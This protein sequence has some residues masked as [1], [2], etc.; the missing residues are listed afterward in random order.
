MKF[1]KVLL[2]LFFF[3]FACLTDSFG[4]IRS[5]TP[6]SISFVKEMTEFLVT[7]RK[8]E[9]EDYMKKEF[10]PAFYSG[11]FTESDKQKIYK[12]CNIMLKK[13]MKPF[14]DFVNYL[15]TMVNFLDSKQSEESFEAW[16]QSLEKIIEKSTSRKFV[17]FLSFSE[18][19]FSGNIL[20]ESSHLRWVSD[21]N[22]YTFEFDS[23]PFVRFNSLN[24]RCESKNDSTVIYGTKGI[25]YPTEGKW[26]GEGGKVNWLR[27][28]FD[29]ASVYANL[30]KYSVQLS[31]ASYIADSVLFYNSYY[32]DKPILGR[33]EEKILANVTEKNASFP[34]FDS[35]NKR[36][37]IR[38]IAQE[39]DYDGGFSMVG[40]KFIGMGSAEEDAYLIFYKDKTPFLVAASKVFVIQKER[41]ISDNSAITIY[42]GS[43][44]IHHPGL[45]MKFLKLNREL[46]L[47]R[48][49]KGVSKTPYYNTFHKIDMDVEVINWKMGEPLINMEVL[50]GSTQT[51][52]RFESSNYYSQ[53]L[54]RKIMGMDN[55]HPLILIREVSKKLNSRDLLADDIA[56]HMRFPMEQ[57]STLLMNLSTQGFLQYDYEKQKVMLKDKL[58]WYLE[59]NAKTRDYDVIEFNSDIGGKPNASLSLLNF[60]L[61]LRGVHQ[62]HLSDSQNVYINPSNQEVVMKKNRDF[63][64]GGMVNAGLFSFYGKEFFFEYDEFK[65]NL[66]TVDSLAIR[67]KSEEVDDYGR[68]K[69]I[70]VKT[71]IQDIK[72]DL[73]IDGPNNKS[74][75][76]PLAHYP[77][78]NSRQESFVYYNRSSIQ[79]G[80]YSK[81]RFYFKV[82]PFQ[83]DSLN[84]FDN[85]SL[86]FNGLFVSAGIFPD[87]TETLTLQPDYSL[88]FVRKTPAGGYPVYGSKATFENDIKMSHEGLRGDG[89]LK[90]LTST[91]NS[92]DFIFYPDSTNAVMES[93]VIE[94]RKGGAV[95]YPEVTARGAYMHYMPYKD[96]MEVE[97]RKDAIAMFKGQAES[98]G[99]IFL[100]PSGLTGRGLMAFSGAEMDANL[101]KYKNNEF[102]SDTCNFRLASLNSAEFALTTDNLN[103]HVDF[104]TRK[105]KFM[106]NGDGSIMNFPP[107]QYVCYM[108]EFTWL[109]DQNDVEI[110]GGDKV[111]QKEGRTDLDL[112]G[113]TFISTHPKQD[114]LSYVAPKSRY[115]L[116]QQTIYSSGVKYFQVADAMV[117]PGDGEVVVEKRAYMR[118]LKDAKLVANFITKFHNIYNSTV[119]VDGRKKYNA[120]GD[121]DYVDEFDKVQTIHF[122][123]INPDSTGQTTANGFIADNINFTL[124]PQFDYKGKVRLEAN[125]QFL[126]FDGVCRINHPCENVPRNWMKFAAEINPKEILIPIAS[127]PLN[128]DNTKLATGMMLATDSIGIYSAF[129]SKKHRPS[130][131]SVIAADGYLYYDKAAQEY[132]ISTREK[133]KELVLPGNFISLNINDCKFYGEGKMDFG[134]DFGSVKFNTAGQAMHNLNNNQALYD[135]VFSMNFFFDEN[136][137]EKMAE[138]M[139]KTS[140]AE[141]I[142]YS[143][144]VF[145]KSLKELLGKEKGDNLI[146]QLNLYGGSYRRFPSEL[147]H[148]IFFTDVKFKWH[149]E[150]RSYRSLGKIGVGN[151]YKNQINRKFDGHI[152]IQKKRGGDIL[153]VYLS[154]GNGQWYF[155]KYQKNFLYAL[156][157]NNEFNDII[158][159]LKPDKKKLKTKKGEAPLTFTISS[160]SEKKKFLRRMEAD[161]EKETD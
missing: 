148:T 55:V 15:S 18:G 17:D 87:F 24:L 106:S 152:E 119:I 141:G 49:G 115:D 3:G 80:A 99:T 70:R 11:R 95:E 88:G 43:D 65:I 2:V 44:S 154:I 25:L 29:D 90:Y 155:F 35:Y 16:Q 72:G 144:Q 54:Y 130:D 91:A 140:G 122:D 7:A 5:F 121:Y 33:L 149:E 123:N 8:K 4:Q 133:L 40:P 108:D 69:L 34:R 131:F 74:G 46:V 104:T 124:S 39:V 161:E 120:S 71:V 136:A 146:S 156:S 83:I 139:Q 126:T 160:D 64:F 23:L 79:K 107:N 109:M 101:Y 86:A 113:S 98:H 117:F 66:I 68:N 20:Y 48:D 93:Y 127:E 27:T 31:K 63:R 82:D 89:T 42:L 59:S 38:N 151:I 129:L 114:S 157:S 147:N 138:Q 12:T 112:T 77:V 28:G 128:E 41:I 134:C 62:I 132:R 50:K 105:A 145:E 14:P 57:V 73:L 142:D 9:G 37:R 58:F 13:R 53:H 125:K 94:E 143:R 1:V 102:F 153:Y 78:L 158:K 92:K 67:V 61:T 159:N 96:L 10:L 6:D 116:K 85:K 51:K 84:T 60:D 36:F 32:F 81:E 103:A 30:Q 137:L 22:N 150:L 97:K 52:A 47:Y 111:A 135:V 76:K 26:I 56:R 21:N 110:S 100:Q 75:L 19:L 45:N 118:P